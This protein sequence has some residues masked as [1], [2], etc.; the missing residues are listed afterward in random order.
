MR[1]VCSKCD[2]VLGQQG[3]EDDDDNVDGN[4]ENTTKMLSETMCMQMG[5]RYFW[6]LMKYRQIAKLEQLLIHRFK[7]RSTMECLFVLQQLM[8]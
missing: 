5:L 8:R 1:L 7:S 4:E 2:R 6:D 3:E